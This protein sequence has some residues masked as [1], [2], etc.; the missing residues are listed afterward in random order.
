MGMKRRTAGHR[1]VFLMSF[2]VGIVMITVVTKEKI[3]Q[4]PLMNRVLAGDFLEE[5]WNRSA[6]FVQC[7]LSRGPVF[8]LLVIL[9]C[10][11]MRTWI[12]RIVIV[13]SGFWLGVLSKMFYLWYGIKGVGL[14]LTAL[15]PQF[16]FYFMAY[17]MLYQ[18][19]EKHRM[20]IRVQYVPVFVAVGVVIMGMVLE[21]YVNPFL[22]N[23]YLKIF[24]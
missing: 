9:M 23:G 2:L 10:T 7:L 19:L 18:N 13:W 15:F 22:V 17:G 5:G 20:S 21:S 8:V 3:P 14:L 1:I 16:L 12:W 11:S 6:L 24:F 4:N